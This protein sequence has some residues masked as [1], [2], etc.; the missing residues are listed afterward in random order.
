MVDK[1]TFLEDLKEMLNSSEDIEMG[2]DLMD[3]ESWDSFS[4]VSFIAMA[5]DKYRATLEPFSIAEAV[6]VEDLYDVV[7]DALRGK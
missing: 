7:N 2:T 4:M 1:I 3:I 5:E 6:L